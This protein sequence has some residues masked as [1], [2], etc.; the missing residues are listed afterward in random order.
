V[1]GQFL[2]GDSHGLVVWNIREMPKLPL[3]G[4]DD[5]IVT[6]NVHYLPGFDLDSLRSQALLLDRSLFFTCAFAVKTKVMQRKHVP[7]RPSWMRCKALR[8]IMFGSP[9]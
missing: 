5:E 1:N 8:E 7:V 6:G 4:L 9:S 3:V 2:A